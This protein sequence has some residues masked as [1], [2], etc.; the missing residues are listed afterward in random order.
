[1]EKVD[2]ALEDV[3]KLSHDLAEA[4]KDKNKVREEMD[5]LKQMVEDIQTAQKAMQKENAEAAA[6]R[7]TEFPA[8][9]N[10][11]IDSK[12]LMK[13][14]T[15]NALDIYLVGLL[16]KKAPTETKFFNKLV[17]RAGASELAKALDGTTGQGLEFIPTLMQTQ[18]LELVRLQNIILPNIPVINPLP[19]NPW[20]MPMNGAGPTVY[21]VDANVSDDGSTGAIGASDPA[22]ANIEFSCGKLAA[23]TVVDSETEED[24]IIAALPFTRTQLVNAISDKLEYVIMRGDETATANGNINKNDGTPTTTAGQKDAYL[25]FDGMAHLAIDGATAKIYDLTTLAFAGITGML[26]LVKSTLAANP[27]NLAM[28]MDSGTYVKMMALSEFLTVD[29]MGTRATILSGSLGSVMGIQVLCSGN[30][31]LTEDGQAGECISTPVT[32]KGGIIMFHRPSCVFGFK[33]GITIKTAPWIIT[34]QDVMVATVRG[35]I[36]FCEGVGSVVLGYDRD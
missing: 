19:S 32:Q 31:G 34:D 14:I 22:T 1:M 7:N 26:A 30:Y 5:N 25:A 35:D 8:E 13:T 18:L 10:K 24:S 23:R 17:G 15:D 4:A 3:K 6:K 2:Q 9:A 29:K 20:K 28:V 27:S 12:E 16:S 33:R 21:A 36:Q 11:A